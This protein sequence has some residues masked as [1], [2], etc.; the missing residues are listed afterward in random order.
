MHQHSYQSLHTSTT[1]K[2]F[3]KLPKLWKKTL[4]EKSAR[5]RGREWRT[6][7]GRGSTAWHRVCTIRNWLARC[8]SSIT[9]QERMLQNFYIPI[10]CILTYSLWFGGYWVTVY[11]L[12]LTF[13][14]SI[15]GLVFKLNKIYANLPFAYLLLQNHHWT[16]YILPLKSL[17]YLI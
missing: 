13:Q 17:Q 8:L 2:K 5:T 4:K 16:S 1:P 7:N 12:F 10:F 6:V 9:G 3:T 15:F 11:H 14:T